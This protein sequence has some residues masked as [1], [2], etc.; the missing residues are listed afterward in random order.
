MKQ[1][2]FSV[3]A[4]LFICG[5]VQKSNEQIPKL[6]SDTPIKIPTMIM[7]PGVPT[8][9]GYYVVTGRDGRTQVYL[10]DIDGF[11]I[12]NHNV[13]AWKNSKKIEIETFKTV[14]N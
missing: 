14:S 11:I 10:T 12:Q 6:T 7:C 3:F 5:C 4:V 1:L 2:V 8:L 9:N 13:C